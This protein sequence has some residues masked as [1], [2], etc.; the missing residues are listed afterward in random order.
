MK[1]SDKLLIVAVFLLLA[2]V[3]GLYFFVI[4]PRLAPL[5]L[6]EPITPPP[7]EE[8][9][10]PLEKNAAL[11]FYFN[12]PLELRG[13][14]R[15]ELTLLHL[16]MFMENG[17]SY[18]VYEGSERIMS[19][20]GILQKVV[21]EKLFHGDLDYLA[22]NLSPTA[23][24]IHENGRSE[25]VFLPNRQLIVP[26]EEGIALNE[27]LNVMIT[28]PPSTAFG[29]K[30]GITTL[31][32]P[33]NITGEQHV[34]TSIFHNPRS[35]GEIYAI[36]KGTIVDAIKADIGLDVSPRTDLEGGTPGFAAPT[37]APVQQP[38]P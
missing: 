15:V 8:P 29:E 7:A 6:P 24:I 33:K 27:T 32:L 13:I 21:S 14:S 16:E 34:M 20:K 37:Q 10:L 5:E 26:I 22:V 17:L 4:R 3:G 28:F 30:N 2:L 1:R 36:E 25:V 18:D 12:S 19:Q 9:A 23:Q 38:A 11:N 31:R 35:N